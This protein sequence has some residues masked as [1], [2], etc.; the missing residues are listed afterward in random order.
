MTW[1]SGARWIPGPGY[2]IFF[3]INALTGASTRLPRAIDGA[4]ARDDEG[5]AFSGAAYELT[6]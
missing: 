6:V 4:G 1:A 3:E 2:T 5:D